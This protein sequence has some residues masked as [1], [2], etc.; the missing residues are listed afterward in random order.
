MDLDYAAL[1]SV[2]HALASAAS[3]VA[4]EPASSGGL[5]SESLR[6]EGAHS[7]ATTDRAS[8]LRAFD[9]VLR[10]QS[11]S[12]TAMVESFQLLDAQIASR[13]TR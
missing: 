11:A 4:A 13:L 5:H 12:L 2:A 6:V 1:T 10:A 9:S 8:T 3:A 7:H